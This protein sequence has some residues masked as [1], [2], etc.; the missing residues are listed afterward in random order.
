MKSRQTTSYT[1]HVNLTEG[2]VEKQAVDRKTLEKYMGGTGIEW[3]LMQESLKPETDPFCSENPISF[4]AGALVGTLAPGAAH[5]SATTL[6]PTLADLEGKHFIASG[7]SGS[8]RFGLML[9]QCGCECILVTGKA[10]APVYLEI[11]DGEANLRDARALWGR[12]DAIETVDALRKKYGQDCGVISIG[13]A[14][15]NLV[16]F[17]MAMVDK[18]GTLGRGGVGA[19]MGSKNL[20]AIAAR[21]AMGIPLA[22]KRRFMRA[23]RKIHDRIRKWPM[24]GTWEKLG[25]GACWPIFK[26]LQNPGKWPMAQWEASYG[27]ERYVREDILE[28]V[29][30]CSSCVIGCKS[31]FAV[32]DKSMDQRISGEGGFFAKIATSMQLLDV[33]D[34]KK[35]LALYALANRAGLCFYTLCRLLD[36]VT[37]CS[38]KGGIK[39]LDIKDGELKRDFSVYM[40][41][42]EKIVKREGIGKIL[43]EGWMGIS[44]EMDL[45]P[46]DYWYAGICKGTDFVYDVRAAKLTP[47]MMSFFTNPR[48][49]HGGSHSVTTAPLKPI[50]EIR[51]QVER[52]GIGPDAIERIFTAAPYS[53]GFNTGRYT[54]YMEDAMMVNNALGLCSLY[55]GFGLFFGDDVAELFSAAK[56]IEVT[57]GDLMKNG[58]RIFT[59]KKMLNAQQG[60]TREDD[61]VPELWLRP[62]DTHE[63]REFTTD[64]FR[65]KVLDAEDFRCLLDDYYDERGWDVKTGLPKLEKISAMEPGA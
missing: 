6:F 30:P 20:K 8:R 46:Q 7:A 63:G 31:G 64:Y 42:F 60:F 17:S 4:S 49:H 38:A 47:L 26:E 24:K 59:I 12:Q 28:G 23:V 34:F 51:N 2:K 29:L 39:G 65:A 55:P 62:L 36:F 3:R 33:K 57:P 40:D 18:S 5:V 15:E 53:A 19:V 25:I 56:G 48:P 14:G 35:G 44:R 10:P 37:T 50:G 16:R 22:D 43:A 27:T 1:L 61:K 54:R 21:G 52:W 9:R 13:P 11:L 41:L 45:D 32:E 58:E